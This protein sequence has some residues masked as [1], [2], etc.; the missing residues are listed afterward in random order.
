MSPRLTEGKKTTRCVVCRAE[1]TDAEIQNAK[2]CP[3][4]GGTGVPMAIAQD[5]DVRINWHE[6]RIL[7][8]WAENFEQSALKN[9][10]N[11]KLG[12]VAAIAKALSKFKPEGGAPLRFAEEFAELQQEYPQAEL[13]DG[14]GNV[15]VSGK[16]LQ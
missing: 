2:A 15:I 7:V 10:P 14:E 12:V 1:F 8:M 16:K 11:H 9:E 5:V 4:C 6:L 13:L 3:S